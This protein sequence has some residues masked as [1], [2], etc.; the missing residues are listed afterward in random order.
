MSDID[1]EMPIAAMLIKG[2]VTEVKSMMSE[3]M[4]MTAKS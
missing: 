3:A 1:W 2:R 4:E